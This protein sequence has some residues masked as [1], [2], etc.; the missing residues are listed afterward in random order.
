MGYTAA[1]AVRI[2]TGLATFLLFREFLARLRFVPGRLRSDALLVLVVVS[3]HRAGRF[4]FYG[5]SRVGP[6]GKADLW[7]SALFVVVILRRHLQS[8]SVSGLV[9]S[10]WQ[11]LTTWDHCGHPKLVIIRCVTYGDST[12]LMGDCAGYRGFGVLQW[13]SVYMRLE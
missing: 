10:E 5:L 4:Q 9:T 12:V 2:V 8:S 13:L 11:R 3:H 1:D 6:L 7:K